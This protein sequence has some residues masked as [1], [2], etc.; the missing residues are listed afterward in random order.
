VTGV[1]PPVALTISFID[2]INRN[3][4]DGLTDLMS[5]DHTLE[6]FD[7]E[8]VA[9]RDANRDAWIDYFMSFP[10]YV[11]Y[12][13]RIAERHGAVAV[14]GHTT[15]S[16]LGLPDDEERELTLIWCA[17]TANV[18]ITRWCLHED[19]MAARRQFDFSD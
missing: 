1:L 12:P 14:L 3:D 11:I 15:G 19:T 16:H 13:H 2:C 18:L 9:G 8:P 10:D 4:I 6:V 5:D 7:E 17:H